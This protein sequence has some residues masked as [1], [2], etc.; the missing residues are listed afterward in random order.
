MIERFFL[1]RV[2][3]VAAR[4]AIGGQYNLTV[5]VAA[6]E[7]QATLAFVQLAI[8]RA[9]VALHPPVVELVPVAGRDHR[10]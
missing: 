5:M 8:T 4:T 9:H 2:H 7:T 10:R 3:A 6:H 1:D